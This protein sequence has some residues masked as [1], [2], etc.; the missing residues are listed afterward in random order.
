MRKLGGGG[1]S[2]GK[3]DY[4]SPPLP[5]TPPGGLLL[6][7]SLQMH[8][9]IAIMLFVDTTL[10]GALPHW[11][12]VESLNFFMYIKQNCTAGLVACQ[13]LTYMAKMT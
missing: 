8:I 3:R 7:N 5:P 13:E 2:G 4:H 11:D 1:G 6:D 12:S 10:T 9:S